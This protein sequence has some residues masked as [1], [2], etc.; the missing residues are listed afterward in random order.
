M[1]RDLPS[2]QQAPAADHRSQQARAVAG[3]EL[4]GTAHV[5][6]GSDALSDGQPVEIMDSTSM[7]TRPLRRR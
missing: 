3:D 5:S 2:C 4:H 7:E 1:M 6:D